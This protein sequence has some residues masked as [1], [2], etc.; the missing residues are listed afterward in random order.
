M[1]LTA[2]AS[3]ISLALSGC[4]VIITTG[5]FSD[6]STTHGVLIV[7]AVATHGTA[8]DTVTARVT[9]TSTRA[10][11]VPR[12][13]TGPLLLTQKLVNGAW[14]DVENA[15]CDAADALQPIELDPGFTLVTVKAFTTGGR[16]RFVTSVG[17]TRDFS[18]S[19]QTA[20]NT[21]ALP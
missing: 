8:L 12:C 5:I 17:E 16:F 9:N 20:S 2:A 11:F 4:S 18:T 6:V 3:A 10:L 19:A 14:I 1:Y 7:A 21:F 15:A 13:G